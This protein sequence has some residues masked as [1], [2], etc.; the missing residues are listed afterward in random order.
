MAK[1]YPYAEFRHKHP[2]ARIREALRGEVDRQGRG[3]PHKVR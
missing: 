2:H 3:S 1:I